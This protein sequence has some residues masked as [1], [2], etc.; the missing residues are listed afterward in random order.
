MQRSESLQRQIN[1]K[2][3]QIIDSVSYDTLVV[4]K[5][6]IT[7]KEQVEGDSFSVGSS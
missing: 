1:E 5:N 6:A 4:I 2:V 7:E 3:A